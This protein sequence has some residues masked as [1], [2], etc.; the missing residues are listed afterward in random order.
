MELRGPYDVA[1]LYPF[2][3]NDSI[4]FLSVTLQL[5]QEIDVFFNHYILSDIN[6]QGFWGSAK[7]VYNHTFKSL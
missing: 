3:C 4:D 6:F 1:N 5:Y 7:P 2:M